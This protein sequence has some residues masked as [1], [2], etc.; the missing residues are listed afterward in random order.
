MKGDRNP[1]AFVCNQIP[2]GNLKQRGARA[3]LFPLQFYID[4]HC[5]QGG[6]IAAARRRRAATEIESRNNAHA[7]KITA[8]PVRGRTDFFANLRLV[9]RRFRNSARPRRLTM[10]VA[11]FSPTTRHSLAERHERH[12]SA[13]DVRVL[14]G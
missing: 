4:H 8:P 1:A 13:R 7:A 9:K 10:T 5:K 12:P 6:K 2:P 11:S 3:A 14:F